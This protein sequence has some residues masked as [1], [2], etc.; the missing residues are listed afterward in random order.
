MHRKPARR[1]HASQ[2][3][4]EHSGCFAPIE[5]NSSRWTAIS[6]ARLNWAPAKWAAAGHE[7]SQEF[8]VP[9]LPW[10]GL[11]EMKHELTVDF[12]W[13]KL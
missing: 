6:Q 5:S 9:V 8:C 7:T 11:E 2:G 10:R 1:S 3:P 4:G 13:Q 12:V